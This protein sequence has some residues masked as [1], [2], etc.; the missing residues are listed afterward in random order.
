LWNNNS[1]GKMKKKAL[2]AG[3]LFLLFSLT[4]ESAKKSGSDVFYPRLIVPSLSAPPEIDGRIETREWQQA[5]CFTGVCGNPLGKEFLLPEA[6]QVTWYLGFYQGTLFIGMRSPHPKGTFPAGRVKEDDDPDV[7]WG[8]H[9]EIQILTHAREDAGKPGKGF[10]KMVIN[11]WGAMH[12]SHYFNGT[13]GTEDLWSTGGQ[14][15]CSVTD[16]YWE[17]ELSVKAEAIKLKTFDGQ[18]LVIQL[19][20]AADTGGMYFAGWVGTNWMD[21]QRFGLVSF[22]SQAPAFRL[23]KLGEIMEGNLDTKVEL[24]GGNRQQ[25]SVRIKVENADGQ[26]IYEEERV[27]VCSPDKPCFLNFTKKGLPIS[28]VELDGKRNMLEITALWK[29]GQQEKILFQHRMPFMKMTPAWRAKYWDPWVAGRP[30]SGEWEAIFSYLP[31]SSRALAKVDVDFFGMPEKIK[32]AVRFT[33][34]IRKKGEKK[35]IAT[36]GATLV[37]GAGET[38]FAVPELPGGEYEAVFRLYS[39]SG[40]SPVA[41]K[42]ENFVR[43]KFPFEHNR[44]GLSEEVIPPFEPLVVSP[45]HVSGAGRKFFA[46]KEIPD[47]IGMWGRLYQIG[48]FGLLKQILTVPPSGTSGSLE[49]L[50][51][52]PM[53]LEAISENKLLE[54]KEASGRIS[55]AAAGRVDVTGSGFL[56]PLKVEAKNFLEYDGWYQV[57]LHLLPGSSLSLDKLDLVIDLRDVPAQRQ[58]ASFPVDTLYVQRLG[59]GL[60]NSY[61]GGIP[62]KPGVHYLSTSLGSG[63]K[64]G[65]GGPADVKKDWKSFAPITF[66]GNGDRGLWFFAWS[67]TGWYLK[68]DDACVRIER[69]ADGNVRLRVRF[70]SGPVTVE[71]PQVIRFALQAAPVKPNDP[72]YRT[73]INSIAH[74]TSGYRYYGDSVDSFSL[75]TDYDYQQL[76][77]FLLYGTSRQDGP[78]TRYDHWAGRLGRMIRHGEAVRIM[79]YGSQWM[80]GLGAEEFDSFGGEWLGRSNWKPHP[81]LKFAEKW[82]YGRTIQWKTP[83]Q[84]TAARVNWPSSMIDFFV[85]YHDRLID[86]AGING[87]WWDN[88]Y[89]GTVTEY[90]PELDRLD[91]KWNLIYRRQLCKRLNVIGWEHMRPPCWAMNTQVELSWCQVYWMV[92]GF[93][94]PSSQDI[95]TLDHF[96]SLDFF[97]A[98]TRPKSTVMI[99]KTSYM[100]HYRGSTPDS[101]RRMKRSSDGILLLHD[102]APVFDQDLIRKLNYLLEYEKSWRCFFM[103]YWMTAAFVQLPEAVVASFYQNPDLKTGVIVFFNTGKK[104]VYLGG[105]SFLP[106]GVVLCT[107]GIPA[108]ADKALSV[109]RVYD[110]ETGQPVKTNFR[111]GRLIIDEPFVCEGHSFRLLA[112]EAE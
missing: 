109:H 52:A 11:A 89:S 82:N 5:A 7:L 51:A 19:V 24:V 8:D 33:V 75:P 86:K 29:Q 88:C 17:M 47:S 2:L 74:D 70:I 14:V 95:S 63:A 44:L 23:T 25:V 104:D 40:G 10:Y 85:W 90:D 87:T 38:F 67:D 41:E 96:G 91:A 31:Y 73:R 57:E 45:T 107:S 18:N 49:P 42:V 64:F 102:I 35:I 43:K 53:R 60:D 13:P 79:L 78:N 112:L 83:R 56:G 111:E 34:D 76:R 27:A 54:L 20:R 21:W 108:E 77:K 26:T 106:S 59:G 30:Q 1:G 39:G 46:G 48:Q 55:S 105:S 94:G 16:E 68:D 66:V 9:V 12:D 15:K 103:G 58:Q 37:S 65:R 81:D 100:T 22:D 84:L 72:Y 92:E 98:A 71:K 6:Q 93:W 101:D 36:S 62:R 80:T 69:L 50:L 99:P 3:C 61:H 97:R 4:G 32:K 28:E 110:L